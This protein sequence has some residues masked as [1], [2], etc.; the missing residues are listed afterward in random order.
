MVLA[1]DIFTNQLFIAANC[2]NKIPSGP[3]TLA[4][5]ISAFTLKFSC[6]I[7]RTLPL[8]VPHD[9]CHRISEWNA[10]AHFEFSPAKMGVTYFNYSTCLCYTIF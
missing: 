4:D 5:K 2:R 10:N 8:D 9:F 1:S 6:N 3:E 7:D